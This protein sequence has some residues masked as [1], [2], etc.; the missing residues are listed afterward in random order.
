MKVAE[1][2]IFDL[3][4]WIAWTCHKLG[5]SLE[6]KIESGSLGPVPRP[7]LLRIPQV[8]FSGLENTEEQNNVCA[9]AT[10]AVLMSGH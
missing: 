6:L 3:P 1:L 5:H 9:S 4:P 10:T 7:S 8:Q 2:K